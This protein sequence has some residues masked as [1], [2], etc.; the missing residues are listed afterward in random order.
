LAGRTIEA[1]TQAVFGVIESGKYELGA[2]HAQHLGRAMLLAGD[3]TMTV[4]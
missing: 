4:V 1:A 2:I 3:Q